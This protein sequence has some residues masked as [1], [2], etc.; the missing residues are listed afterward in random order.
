MRS[1]LKIPCATEHGHSGLCHTPHTLC[2][3]ADFACLCGEGASE[4]EKE[5]ARRLRH[6]ENMSEAAISTPRFQRVL[7]HWR[8][9]APRQSRLPM[10]ELY[11]WATTG[12]LLFKNVAYARFIVTYLH[13]TPL[14]RMCAKTSSIQK[15]ASRGPTMC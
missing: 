14:V 8:K 5:T 15:A 3:W 1:P 11:I 9:V 4:G 12:F 6:M 7:R 10:P 2:D 13:P